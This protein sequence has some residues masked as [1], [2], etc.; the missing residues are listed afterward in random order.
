MDNQD[1]GQVENAQPNA[2]IFKDSTPMQQRSQLNS[3]LDGVTLKNDQAAGQKESQLTATSVKESTAAA[4]IRAPH[5][6][7]TEL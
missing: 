6:R 3:S 1:N 7:R 4:L 2:S 5:V